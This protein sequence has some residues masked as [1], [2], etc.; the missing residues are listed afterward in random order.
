MRRVLAVLIVLAGAVGGLGLGAA[1]R[2]AEPVVGTAVGDAGEARAESP[3]EGTAEGAQPTGM[4]AS[5]DAASAE[6]T[7]AAPA[8]GDRDYVKLARQLIVPVVEEGETRALMLFELALDV[9]RSM[10]ERAYAAEPRLRDAFLK[11]LMEMSYTGAFSRTYTD[12]RVVEELRDKLRSAA[13]GQLG[14]AA[15]DIL[16]LD[17]LR[18][19]L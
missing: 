7:N 1:L 9:P 4:A 12:E 15:A 14:G 17:I 8:P 19:E 3:S 10:T 5:A 6:A 13:R 2:P 11:V 16:I 18:Q